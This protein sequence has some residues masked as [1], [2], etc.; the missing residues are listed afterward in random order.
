MQ[1]EDLSD[2]DFQPSKRARVCAAAKLAYKVGPSCR[3][4]HVT[5]SVGPEHVGKENLPPEGNWSALASKP[6][7]Q[8]V[9]SCD[10]ELEVD[11]LPM[12]KAKNCLLLAAKQTVIDSPPLHEQPQAPV[13]VRAFFTRK[14][15]WSTHCNRSEQCVSADTADNSNQVDA[16]L[17]HSQ[18]TEAIAYTSS[19][20]SSHAACLNVASSQTAH[21]VHQVQPLDLQQHTLAAAAQLSKSMQQASQEHGLPASIAAAGCAP[22]ATKRR[23]E[24]LP[25]NFIVLDSSED[26][27]SEASDD[28]EL[29]DM[30]TQAEASQ[31]AVVAWL[32]Q[33]GLSAYIAAFEQAEVDLD[34]IPL[35]SD[36][37][38]KQMGVTA[39]GPR[40][41][42]LAAAAKLS[43]D[44]TGVPQGTHPAENAA[45]LDCPQ[46]P[47]VSESDTRCESCL[48]ANL[49]C[50]LL[51]MHVARYAPVG[52]W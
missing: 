27:A 2:Q 33:H 32:H 34:F 16:Q 41:K 47:V 1:S 46:V 44:N 23:S 22:G 35:L 4:L 45:L 19:A 39:L 11:L 6:T 43:A 30:Q 14:S 40:R 36:D 49:A 8:L 48:T 9:N 20:Y 7:L 15:S 12:R 52:L 51:R 17:E 21:T 24:S 5:S 29:A 26:D 50:L 13:T 10:N 3:A 28:P 42:I 31:Q 18:Q 38:L 37:D 25:G